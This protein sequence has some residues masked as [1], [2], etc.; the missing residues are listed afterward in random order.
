MWEKGQTGRGVAFMLPPPE[1]LYSALLCP[2]GSSDTGL[3]RGI[4]VNKGLCV[5]GKPSSQ[6]VPGTP[7]AIFPFP[8]PAACRDKDHGSCS[9]QGKNKRCRGTKK[10]RKWLIENRRGGRAKVNSKE[11]QGDGR[12]EQG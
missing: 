2:V 3:E 7:G 12:A 8:S 9:P 10:D 6:V 11:L 1:R 4:S 5:V